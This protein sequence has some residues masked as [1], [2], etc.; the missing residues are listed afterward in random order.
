VAGRPGPRAGGG[1]QAVA[2]DVDRTERGRKTPADVLKE[3]HETRESR[4][5]K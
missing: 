5:D 1:W 2:S 4:G 3:L